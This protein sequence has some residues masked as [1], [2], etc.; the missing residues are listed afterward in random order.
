M[1]ERRCDDST[2]SRIDVV[3][4]SWEAALEDWNRASL[5]LTAAPGGW[6]GC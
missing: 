3:A 4:E 1:T 2:R 6:R 5:D